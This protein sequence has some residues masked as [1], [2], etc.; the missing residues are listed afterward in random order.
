M[1]VHKTI[2]IGNHN[3]VMDAKKILDK[4]TKSKKSKAQFTFTLDIQLVDELKKTLK[5]GL[6][7]Q[8]IEELLKEFLVKL[9]K[10]KK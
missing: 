4:A 3:P 2:K 1:R 8:V 6:L 10:E 9:E 7:S 5:K